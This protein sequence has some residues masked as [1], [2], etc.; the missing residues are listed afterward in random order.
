MATAGSASTC[1]PTPSTAA[2]AARLRAGLALCDGHLRL[3]RRGL[4]RQLRRQVQ[5]HR[6]LLGQHLRDRLPAGSTTCGV[7]CTDR[8][9][10]AQLRRLRQALLDG[11]VCSAGTCVCRRDLGLPGDLHRPADGSL[12]LWRLRQ[13]LRLRQLRRRKVR[14][15]RAPPLQ[16][17]VRLDSGQQELRELRRGLPERDPV[18]VPGW[19]LPAW[20]GPPSCLPAQ[21]GLP[22]R[23]D[24]V[25]LVAP[26]PAPPTSSCVDTHTDVKNCG[27]CNNDCTKFC[28]Y[29][30]AYCIDG[31]CQCGCQAPRS[32]CGSSC[33]DTQEDRQLR[34]L[35]TKCGA[36]LGC[37][38]G[39]VRPARPA[40]R[41]APGAASTP[42]PMS[43]TA[44]AAPGCEPRAAS[45]RRHQQGPGLPGGQ[46]RLP[47]R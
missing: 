14:A 26:A 3:R 24:P 32:L 22:R 33:V 2:A 17:Q 43:G 41:S 40:P 39:S 13:H 27:M 47:E 35:R 11:T 9:A 8:A 15:P 44:V 7:S 12:Q 37:Y 45:L 25:L 19:L 5:D 23:T 1:K 28:F 21:P 16:R 4:R 36:G 31:S 46:V 34:H 6:G 20:S 38:K 29:G 42:A 30:G 18:P 10:T